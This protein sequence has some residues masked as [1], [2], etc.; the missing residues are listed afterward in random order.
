MTGGSFGHGQPSCV[1]CT[2]PGQRQD[3]HVNTNSCL[4]HPGFPSMLA[5][6]IHKA[7]NVKW[8]EKKKSILLLSC[9]KS[10]LL[11]LRQQGGNMPAHPT[12]S[13]WQSCWQSPVMTVLKF[14]LCTDLALLSKNS[15]LLTAKTV[16]LFKKN[17]QLALFTSWPLPFKDKA[18]INH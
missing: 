17:Q 6:I 10:R 3:S 1:S 14:S 12:A 8:E 5:W 7:I 9:L 13:W 18:V 16:D 11:C 4:L 2:G 15:W